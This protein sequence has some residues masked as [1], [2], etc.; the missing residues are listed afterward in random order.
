MSTSDQDRNRSSLRLIGRSGHVI[1][2]LAFIFSLFIVCMPWGGSFKD[3]LFPYALAVVLLVGG[4][5]LLSYLCAVIF[6]TSARL[7]KLWRRHFGS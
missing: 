4:F 5:M 6:F 1:C 3:I 2:T 7:G